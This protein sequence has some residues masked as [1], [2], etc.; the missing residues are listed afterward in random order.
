MEAHVERVADILNAY[1]IS[2]GKKNRWEEQITR[3]KFAEV[4]R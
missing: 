3:L 4:N 2:V 1:K